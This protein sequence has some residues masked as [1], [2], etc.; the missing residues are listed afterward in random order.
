MTHPILDLHEA[1]ALGFDREVSDPI[2]SITNAGA[3]MYSN[4][5]E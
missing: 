5:G 4:R 2:D 3:G 1:T